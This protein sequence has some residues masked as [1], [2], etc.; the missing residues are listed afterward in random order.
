[1]HYRLGERH[2]AVSC[3]REALGLAIQWKTPLARRW[4]AGLLADFGDACQAAGDLPNA[5]KA[6]QQARQTL[7]DLGLPDSIGVRAR[8]HRAKPAR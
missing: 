2:H 8:L 5:R 7:H 3:Y 6:W 4:L 1:V